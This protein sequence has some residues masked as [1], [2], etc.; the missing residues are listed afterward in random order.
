MLPPWNKCNHFHNFLILTSFS[1]DNEIA[2]IESAH[3]ILSTQLGYVEENMN[4][5]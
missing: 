3:T 5:M 1:S 2:V 4:D